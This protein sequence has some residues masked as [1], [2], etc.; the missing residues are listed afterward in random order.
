[1]KVQIYGAGIA[2]S[3]L[4]HLLSQN[5]FDVAIYDIRSKPDCRCAWGFSYS[6]TKSLYREIGIDVDD[7][8]LS[9]PKYVVVNNRLW[10]KNKEIVILDKRRLMKDLWKFE[11]KEEGGDIIVDATGHSRAILPK[12][13]NDAIYATVQYVEKHDLDENIYIYMVRTG[14][15][16]A[17]PLGDRWHIGAGD[18]T[19]EKALELIERLREIYGLRKEKGE[20]SCVGK[21]RLLPPSRCKP[22]V[23]ENVYGVGESI[24][25]VSGAGEGNAPSLKCAK[26]FYNCLT[27]GR[28]DEYEKRVLDEFWWI[29]LEHEFV[30]AVQ[31]GKRLKT[32]RLLPK[33]ISVES[34]RSVE[35]SFETIKR[36]LSFLR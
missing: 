19:K 20:C 5:G 12:I 31:N 1:M 17:F 29:E 14:Y 15:A 9:K 33:I 32:L 35:Q 27:E 25:C 6:E 2:G 10:L 4:Y 7:Y 28:L 13:K 3:Y 26:I 24:G 30:S 36:L 11:L 22:I 34:K 21:I 16:W 18:L 8:I 23:Y